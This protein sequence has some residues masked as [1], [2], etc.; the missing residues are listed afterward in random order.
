MKEETDIRK[1]REEDR[2]IRG[3]IIERTSRRGEQIEEQRQICHLR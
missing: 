3:V 1:E 2:L